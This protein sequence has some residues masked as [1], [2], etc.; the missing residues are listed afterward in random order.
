MFQT[1]TNPWLF[2]FAWDDGGV[3]KTDLAHDT[4]GLSISVV[5]GTAAAASL[6]PAA[7]SSATDWAAGKLWQVNGNLYKI[8]CSIA[9]ISDYIGMIGAAGSYTGGTIDPILQEVV[10]AL[11]TDDD[12]SAIKGDGWTD[13]TLENIGDKTA[14]LTASTAVEYLSHV[15][16]DG[17]LALTIGD[18]YQGTRYRLEIPLTDA[19]QSWFDYLTG[20]TVTSITFSARR[21]LS[22]RAGII[23]GT[24][25][26][27]DITHAAGTTT[28][29]V[30]ITSD[31]LGTQAGDFDYHLDA[32]DADGNHKCAKGELQLSLDA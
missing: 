12:I 17:T 14:N 8:G 23:T 16:V 25:D 4:A 27:G 2:F 28:I 24:I 11:A 20:E 18:D 6:T 26:A 22:K 32:V 29:V 9:S 1:E 19:D 30:E 10:P 31:Q 3:A 5:K 15:Q 13:Q 7:A 21:K